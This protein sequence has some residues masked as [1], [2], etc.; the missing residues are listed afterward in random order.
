MRESID[1][2]GDFLVGSRVVRRRKTAQPI[3][4]R[5]QSAEIDHTRA[6]QSKKASVNYF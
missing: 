6:A 1:H 3:A 2:N 4:K 5:R